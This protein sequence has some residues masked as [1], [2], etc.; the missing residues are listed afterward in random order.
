MFPRTLRPRGFAVTL[1]LL[2]AG[3]AFVESTRTTRRGGVLPPEKEE[4]RFP[5]GSGAPSGDAPLGDDDAKRVERARDSARL[6]PTG[7]PR[8]ID[9]SSYA[10][11]GKFDWSRKTLVAEADITL[12]VLD[13]SLDK[14]ELDS[15]VSQI[16]AVKRGEQV[17]PF[18]VRVEEGLAVLDIT[19]LSPAE[20]SKPLTFTIAYEAPAGR[21]GL[22]AV[23]ARQGDTA[24]G[25]VVYTASEPLGVARWMPCHN[26]PSDRAT[27]SITFELD[28]RENG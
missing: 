5:R 25:R 11:R 13:A 21:G 19:R 2:Y 18:E 27:F 6:A 10:L 12:R 23:A 4:D 9:V 3:C 7:A 17:V 15:R 8:P 22:H 20:K 16:L 24:P 1:F 14:I 26:V 28:E